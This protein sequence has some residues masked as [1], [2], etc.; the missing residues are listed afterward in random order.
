[1]SHHWKVSN[2]ALFQKDLFGSHGGTGLESSGTGG[3][4]NSQDAVAVI[5]GLG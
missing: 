4:E 5:Q 1:M 3:R 2:T